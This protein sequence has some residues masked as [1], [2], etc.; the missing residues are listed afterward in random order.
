MVG[1]MPRTE[2][3]SALL[4]IALPA[5]VGLLVAC[6]GRACAAGACT[7][8]DAR[9]VVETGAHRLALNGCVGLATDGEM[10]TIAAW[11]RSA[12]AGTIELR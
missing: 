12:H 7:S 10:A 2:L 1:R 6:P 11:V 8:A 4:R 9:I 5:V 3:F